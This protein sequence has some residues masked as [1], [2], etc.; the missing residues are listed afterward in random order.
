MAARRVLPVALATVLALG[1]AV[2]V[3]ASADSPPVSGGTLVDQCQANVGPVPEAGPRAC[4]TGQSVVWGTA[5]ACRTPL[6]DAPAAD[7]P[8]QC[9]VID[10]RP[11]SEAR[12][13]AYESSWVHRALSLQRG[14]DAAAPLFEEQLP[15]TH[16]TFNS[17]AYQVSRSR[18]LGMR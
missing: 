5:A 13:A 10:G 11:V 9:A 1:V 7:A 15:H 8:E 6:R 4:R 14:L 16:N 18:S 3:A 12:V 2:P 17:S